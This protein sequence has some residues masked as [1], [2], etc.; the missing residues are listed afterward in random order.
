MS[1]YVET[2]EAFALALASMIELDEAMLRDGA[3]RRERR[4]IMRELQKAATE[5]R[6]PVIHKEETD[7]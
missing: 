2:P 1:N 6:V 7:A 4:I 3:T 5:N